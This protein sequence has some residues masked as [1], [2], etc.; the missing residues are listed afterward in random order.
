MHT[1]KYA[2]CYYRIVGLNLIYVIENLQL[3]FGFTQDGKVNI[4]QS[5]KKGYKQALINTFGSYVKNYKTLCVFRHLMQRSQ[6]WHEVRKAKNSAFLC[7]TLA[8]LRL[9]SGLIHKFSSKLK[10]LK[11][12]L[13][14]FNKYYRK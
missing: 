10:C 5:I 4:N 14:R 1:V 6:N 13:P 8:T 9:N 7:G 11:K 2:D 12:P 3:L